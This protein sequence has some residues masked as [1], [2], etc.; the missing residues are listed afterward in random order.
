METIKLTNFSDFESQASALHKLYIEKKGEHQ[1]NIS[2]LLFRGQANSSWKLETTL[3][4]HTSRRYSTAEYY[5][6]MQ[7]TRHKVES[8]TAKKWALPDKFEDDQLAP[9]APQG[10]EFMVYLR[11]HGFPSPLL[12]WTRS[13]YV[14]SF[15]AYNTASKDDEIAIY[16]YIEY[17]NMAKAGTIG[18][19]TIVGCGPCITTHPRHFY[20]Q[21]DYTF[22]KKKS[23]GKF[24]YCSHEEAFVRNNEDQDLLIKFIL[25]GTEKKAVLNRLRLM[26]ITA[27]SLFGSEESLLSTIASEEIDPNLEPDSN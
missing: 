6:L 1:F 3:E 20:Q 16:A 2:P 27:F 26:N 18:D 21:C 15:F 13:P 8:F 10:Y 23:N 9:H 19:A 4:R 7:I 24:I 17:P 14:A 25:P 12:D 22:C 11:H 5:R